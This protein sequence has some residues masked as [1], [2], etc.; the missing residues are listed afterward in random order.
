MNNEAVLKALF[1]INED[2]LTF[3]KAVQVA[4]ESEDAAKEAKATVRC[5][6]KICSEKIKKSSPKGSPKVNSDSST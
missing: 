5:Q 2:E 3:A 4:T 1:K 6:R